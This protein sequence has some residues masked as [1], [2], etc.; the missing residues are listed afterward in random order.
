MFVFIS[1]QIVLKISS[2]RY[3]S[4]L[5]FN[6]PQSPSMKPQFCWNTNSDLDGELSP[7]HSYNIFLYQIIIGL[8]FVFFVE[9]HEALNV[10]VSDG[11]MNMVTLN[12]TDDVNTRI[13][14]LQQQ[15]VSNNA[16][17]V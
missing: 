15:I 6:L 3:Q 13:D 14:Q 17:G 9:I 10:S 7:L 5:G 2:S 8:F 16:R 4:M 1:K 12:E 11:N